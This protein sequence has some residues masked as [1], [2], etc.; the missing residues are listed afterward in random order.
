MQD[1]QY[2]LRASACLKRLEDWLEDFDPDELDFTPA[3][4]VVTMEFA[5]GTRYVLNRQSAAAQIWFA[6]R[7]RAW[8]FNYDEP[9]GSW[10]DDKEGHD[11]WSRVTQ[12]VGEKLGRPVSI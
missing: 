6:A 5:D 2:D 7:T 4:G 12:A 1:N 11:L 8:H 9:S 3:D 10:L